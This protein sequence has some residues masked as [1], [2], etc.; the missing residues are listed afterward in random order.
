MYLIDQC[1]QFGFFEVK[2][3]I[4]GLFSTPLDVL[5]VLFLKRGQMKFDFIG[6]LNFYVTLAYI[7]TP[8]DKLLLEPRIL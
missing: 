5:D 6:Q 1:C 7:W 4:F 3:V 8:K 2:F